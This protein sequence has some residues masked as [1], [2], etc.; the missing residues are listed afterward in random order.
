MKKILDYLA[1]IWDNPIVLIC[2]SIALAIIFIPIFSNVI[3]YYIF[4]LIIALGVSIGLDQKYI[5]GFTK[6]LFI[7]IVIVIIFTLI[8]SLIVGDTFKDNHNGNDSDACDIC[9][10][11]GVLT[12]K[13]LGEGTGIQVGFDTYYRCK[14]C[15]GSGR[16]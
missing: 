6:I 8:L 7:A 2:I 5:F 4:F 3:A 9:G 10:G 13:L 12:F 14:G 16:K 15:H 1:K 11:S